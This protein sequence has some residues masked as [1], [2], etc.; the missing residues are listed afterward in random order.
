[1]SEEGVLSIGPAV[2]T[3]AGHEQLA[4]HQQAMLLRLKAINSKS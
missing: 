3:M 1:L 4:A 2:S